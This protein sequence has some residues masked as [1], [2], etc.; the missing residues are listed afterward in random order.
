VV[1]HT[2]WWII[3]CMLSAM[4]SRIDSNICTYREYHQTKRPQRCRHPPGSSPCLL[5][6]PAGKP[7]PFCRRR[8][9]RYLLSRH[10]GLVRLA[11]WQVASK[12]RVPTRAGT[13]RQTRRTRLQWSSTPETTTLPAR[14]RGVPQRR[15][16]RRWSWRALDLSE[17]CF[18]H[19]WTSVGDR[20]LAN[21]IPRTFFSNLLVHKILVFHAGRELFVGHLQRFECAQSSA[22]GLGRSLNSLSRTTQYW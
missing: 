11:N 6:D 4:V 9:P 21:R 16:C 8:S 15:S 7:C 12:T 17:L 19:K 10:L 2:S 1:P 22:Q 13:L 18:L 3:S 14:G 5:Q 20:K